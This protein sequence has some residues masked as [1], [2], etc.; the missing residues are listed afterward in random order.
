MRWTVK[1]GSYNLQR[2]SYIS[3]DFMDEAVLEIKY[4]KEYTFERGYWHKKTREINFQKYEIIN[5]YSNIICL[6]LVN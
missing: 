2:V 4:L 6:S 3:I 1:N 5:T